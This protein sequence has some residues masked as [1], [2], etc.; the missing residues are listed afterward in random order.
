MPLESGLRQAQQLSFFTDIIF[1]HI[2]VFCTFLTIK[3]FLNPP[4]LVDMV[5]F[6]SNGCTFCLANKICLN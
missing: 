3:L 2:L 6:Y 1:N 4:N 5:G